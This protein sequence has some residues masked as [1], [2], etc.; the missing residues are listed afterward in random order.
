MCCCGAIGVGTGVR[1]VA[2]AVKKRRFAS[3]V[4]DGVGKLGCCVAVGTTVDCGSADDDKSAAVDE[5][6]TVTAAAVLVVRPGFG[7]I[8]CLLEVLTSFG[9]NL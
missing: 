8:D 5:A 1:T 9:T 6:A 3:C 2:S 7:G 4:V